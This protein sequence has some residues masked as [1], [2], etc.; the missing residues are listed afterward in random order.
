MNSLPFVDTLLVDGRFNVLEGRTMKEVDDL[1][2]DH[3]FLPHESHDRIVVV[4]VVVIFIG[5][6]PFI[7]VFGL[8]SRID[9]EIVF[10]YVIDA[11]SPVL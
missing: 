5:I 2:Q 4:V 10:K 9:E 7:V 3:Q 11:A 1:L 8:C 6:V